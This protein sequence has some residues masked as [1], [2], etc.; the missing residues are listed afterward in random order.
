MGV[1]ISRNP[2]SVMA[3]RMADTT[4]HRRIMFFLT[5]GFLRSR[6]RYFSRS[7][8][9]ASRL[10]FTWKGSSLYRH[11]PSTSI[12]SGTTSISPVGRLAFLLLRSRTVPSTEITVSL[13][14]PWTAFIISSVSMTTCVVP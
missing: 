1:V 12:F 2:W 5:S 6:Y 4:L 11:L 14:S 8:S 9:S 7:V 3:A 13:L 10:R